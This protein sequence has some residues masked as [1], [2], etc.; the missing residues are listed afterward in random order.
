MK[1]LGYKCMD[2]WYKVTKE[3]IHKNGGE[4][5][6][7]GYYNNSPSKA[8]MN[9]YPE[10]NW[11]LEKSK[12][13]PHNFWKDQ[14]NQKKFFNSLMIKL[15]YKCM[16]DWYKVTQEDIHKNG[17]RGPLDYYNNSPSQALATVYPQ[18]KWEPWKFQSVPK[19]YWEKLMSNPTSITAVVGWS[20]EQLCIK[21]LDDWY[22]ISM[23]QVHKFIP[24]RS[25]AV[26]A[27]LLQTAHP[28]HQWDIT[29]LSRIGF[30][31]KASQREVF[32]AVQRLF[33]THSKCT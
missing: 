26:L 24:V 3:D 21:H 18:H 22:R 19:G 6:L 10:H 13:T 27:K 9:I 33:P 29:L 1:K 20:G 16:D 28:Q 8:L 12:Q 31:I 23:T 17:G 11:E 4:R 2:D 15:G 25:A 5:P 32:L 14:E 7:H 30:C